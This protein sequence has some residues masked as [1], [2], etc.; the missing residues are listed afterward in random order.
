MWAFGIGTDRGIGTTVVAYGTGIIPSESDMIMVNG[1]L[2]F[3]CLY[4]T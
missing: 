2:V 4:F 3:L 1:I